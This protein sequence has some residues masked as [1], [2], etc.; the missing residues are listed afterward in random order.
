MTLLK[1]SITNGG[2]RSKLGAL[3]M[4]KSLYQLKDTLDY[5]K[6]GGAVLFG[7]KAQS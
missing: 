7:L 4:K 2:M 5:E 6:A 1:A 3:F